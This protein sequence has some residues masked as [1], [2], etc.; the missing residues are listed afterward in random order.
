V[1]STDWSTIEDELLPREGMIYLLKSIAKGD[2]E[3]VQ[4][5]CLT[6]MD[7]AGCGRRSL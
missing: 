4:L 6:P 3:I 5:A 7:K 2:E 1:L